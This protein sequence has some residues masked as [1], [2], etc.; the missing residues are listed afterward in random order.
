MSTAD[1]FKWRMT[2]TLVDLERSLLVRYGIPTPS[3][4]QYKDHTKRVSQSEGGIVRHGYRNLEVLWLKLDQCQADSVRDFYEAAKAG[5]G[6]L[7]MTVKPLDGRNVAWMDVSGRP[8]LSDIAPDAPII[9][10]RGYI[11]SNIKLT[12]NNVVVITEDPTF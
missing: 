2:D 12:L 1:L 10:A 7:Y 9:G 11:H 5:A 6:L 4:V 8:D 3:Q